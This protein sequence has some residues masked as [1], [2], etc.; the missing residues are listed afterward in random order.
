MPTY[1]NARLARAGAGNM[2]SAM[3]VT[4]LVNEFQALLTKLLTALFLIFV[5]VFDQRRPADVNEQPRRC[6]TSPRNLNY[7]RY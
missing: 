3:A 2:A 1:A 7:N 6:N 4:P 5:Y